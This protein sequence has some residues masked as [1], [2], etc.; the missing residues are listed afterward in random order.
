M[1]F[2][3]VRIHFVSD[4][5]CLFSSKNF[6]TMEKLRNDFSLFQLTYRRSQYILEHPGAVSLAGRKGA[7]KTEEPLGSFSSTTAVVYEHMKRTQEM[8]FTD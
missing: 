3:A 7:S 5:F 6:A 1:K 4:V 8:L 2:E